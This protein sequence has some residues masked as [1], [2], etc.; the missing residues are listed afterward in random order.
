MLGLRTIVAACLMIPFSGYLHCGLA[1]GGHVTGTVLV[2]TAEG[3][4]AYGDWVRVLLVSTPVA[5]P[6]PGD[7]SGL[8]RQQRIDR[9]IHLH[10]DFFNNIQARLSE[11][12]YL[13]AD[14]LTTPDGGFKFHSIPPGQYYLVVTFPSIIRGYKVAWQVA[15]RIA[16]G[17]TRQIELNN[18]NMAVPTYSRY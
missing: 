3:T 10:L 17:Q 9:L 11:P 12:G 16:E 2:T 8:D 4:V 18:E 15:V 1:A 6:E 7:L 13:V 14:T 5:V